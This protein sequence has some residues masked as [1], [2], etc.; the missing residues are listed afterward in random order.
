MAAWHA[1]NVVII[2][3]NPAFP[4]MQY[5]TAVGFVVCGFGLLL[6]ALGRFRGISVVCGGL[7]AL[8]S[9]AVLA[10]Y[11]TGSE[12]GFPLLLSRLPSA[13]GLA[14]HLPSPPTAV[15]FLLC[16]VG[17]ALLGTRLHPSLL[18]LAIWGVG[19]LGLT[20]S[21][22]VLVGY[23]SGLPEIY[24]WGG[25]IGM[26]PHTAAGVIVLNLGLLGSLWRGDRSILDDRWL[27]VPAALAL[28]A[29]TVLLWQAIVVERQKSLQARAEAVAQ[30]LATATSLQLASPVRAL[31]RMKARWEKR[32]GTPRGEWEA[33]AEAC[34]RD[35]KILASIE[36]VDADW[37]VQWA[38]PPAWQPC[39]RAKISAATRAGP[40]QPRWSRRSAPGRWRSR[41][42]FLSRP[43][44]RV[45]KSAS[46][47]FPKVGS[48][49]FSSRR[50]G[51]KTSSRKL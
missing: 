18:R 48:T 8:G 30:G 13:P 20:L 34:I 33:D 24:V 15:A 32:G 1:G 23:A 25:E 6:H 19:A 21:A 40:R 26:S 17:I 36:W 16:G 9:M 14:P 2:D 4:A 49:A 51:C 28:G 37:R 50:S 27:P 31:E 47:F 39:G 41:R 43:A 44:G 5:L 46:R 38:Q 11:V 45:T 22:M 42:A 12:M 35:E 10:Q 7:A 29:A 3:L